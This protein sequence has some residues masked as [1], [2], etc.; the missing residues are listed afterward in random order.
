MD[1]EVPGSADVRP[2]ER[3][4]HHC[5]DLP[6]PAGVLGALEAIVSLDH[7]VQCAA[8]VLRPKQWANSTIVDLRVS[9]KR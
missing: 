6:W 2:F 3:P 8:A 4:G 5:I 7:A 1:E 9:H